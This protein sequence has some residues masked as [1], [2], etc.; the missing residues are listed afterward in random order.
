MNSGFRWDRV[1]L[2]SFAAAMVLSAGAVGAN[3]SYRYEVN[4]SELYTNI[5]YF[6]ADGFSFLSPGLIGPDSTQ[7]PDSPYVPGVTLTPPGELNGFEFDRFNWSGVSW[8]G[9]LTLSSIH[10]LSF[11]PAWDLD[12]DVGSVVDLWIGIEFPAGTYGPG[13]Y[14]GDGFGRGIQYGGGLIQYEYVPGTMVIRSVPAVPAPGA[15]VLGGLGAGLVG[16]RRRRRMR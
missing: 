15:I 12:G 14:A 8:T 7:I 6:P 4:Y 16:W 2:S 11:H 5:G 10:G 9:V 13:V 3:A 1:L